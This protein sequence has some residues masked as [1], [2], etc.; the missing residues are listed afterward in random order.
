M[1]QS[2]CS[3]ASGAKNDLLAAGTLRIECPEHQGPTQTR[4]M[5]RD[6]VINV[7]QHMCYICHTC[8][9]Q[10]RHTRAVFAS[11]LWW[12]LKVLHVNLGTVR[13]CLIQRLDGGISS[14][15]TVFRIRLRVI[16][17]SFLCLGPLGLRSTHSYRIP[18]I[19]SVLCNEIEISVDLLFEL[20]SFE[21]HRLLS[22]NDEHNQILSQRDEC[23]VPVACHEPN[24]C[25]GTCR[26]G[27]M[28][29][30]EL[31]KHNSDN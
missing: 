17:S 5:V 23:I 3:G 29:T 30:H 16:G 24:L 19:I 21:S 2:H 20:F 26:I 14:V 9:Y 27:W 7:L 8:I 6:H 10:N 13:R 11:E 25:R 12:I 28:S 31:T 18:P 1:W 22:Q 4:D 15:Q